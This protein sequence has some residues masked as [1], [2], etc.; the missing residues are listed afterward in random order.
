MFF[1][2]ASFGFKQL[3]TK[4]GTLDQRLSSTPSTKG[5]LVRNKEHSQGWS[6][7]PRCL[8]GLKNKILASSAQASSSQH[9]CFTYLK[10][11]RLLGSILQSDDGQGEGVDHQ[12]ADDSAAE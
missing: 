3:F 12:V 6:Y 4:P 9:V 7:I 10:K 11:T 8:L 1:Q 2:C 5:S